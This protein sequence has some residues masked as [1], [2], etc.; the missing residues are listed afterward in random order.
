M[1]TVGWPLSFNV[2]GM[3]I[4]LDKGRFTIESLRDHT[5]FDFAPP[6]FTG[7]HRLGDI[8]LR[9]RNMDNTSVLFQAASSATTPL[10]ATPLPLVHGELAAVNL[11]AALNV[12]Q[13][14]LQRRFSSSAPHGL[15]M[16]FV[17][18]NMR[19]V[20]V[21]VGGWGASMFFGL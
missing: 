14:L 7:S 18:T 2:S 19:H 1:S 15:R 8:T 20:A 5:G 10:A 16:A 17:L 12:P 3:S 9:Y 6:S 4:V 13:L 11:T 21:E